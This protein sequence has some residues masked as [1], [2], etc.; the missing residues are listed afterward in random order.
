[1]LL[2]CGPLLALERS[3]HCSHSETH[4]R[5]I[6][7]SAESVSW[8]LQ[9]LYADLLMWERPTCLYEL[10][11]MPTFDQLRHQNKYNKPKS[12]KLDR[13]LRKVVLT[14]RFTSWSFLKFFYQRPNVGSSKWHPQ[15]RI[16]LGVRM[17]E[18]CSEEPTS[19]I[20]RNYVSKLEVQ[21][22]DDSWHHTSEGEPSLAGRDHCLQTDGWLR[23][24]RDDY[25]VVVCC[26]V[27]WSDSGQQQNR[28]GER[29]L[30]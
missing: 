2:A 18:Q 29:R 6:I 16:Q 7:N 5:E 25:S 22:F 24:P 13:S 8:K 20:A 14:I 21:T 19:F 12:A 27:S 10:I 23:E 9:R 26:T 15:R 17:W 28:R 30:P 11:S 4:A 1:M 3:L